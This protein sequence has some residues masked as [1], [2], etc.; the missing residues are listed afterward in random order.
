MKIEEKIREVITQAIEAGK[1]R[2]Y[3]KSITLLTEIVDSAPQYPAILLYLGRSYHALGNYHMAVQVLE[4]YNKL[5]PESPIGYF[6]LARTYYQLGHYKH[7]VKLLKFVIKKDPSFAFAHGLLGYIYLKLNKYFL[8]MESF[9]QSVELVPTDRRFFNGYLN[10]LLV[11][12]IKLFYKGE[13]EEAG[14]LF[15]YILNNRNSS[16]TAHLYLAFIFRDLGKPN[17]ALFHL[18]RVIEASGNDPILHLNRAIILLQKGDRSGGLF[19]L[20]NVAKIMNR[21]IK[22]SDDIEN[23]NRILAVTLFNDK[24]Y[25]KAIYFASKLLKL[26]YNQPDLHALIGES[27]RNLGEF[28]KA[29]NHFLRAIEINPTNVA[30]RYGLVMIYW[31]LS[32]YTEIIKQLNRIQHLSPDDSIASYYNTLAYAKLGND[33]TKIIALLQR[34]IKKTGPDIY[35]MNALGKAYLDASIPDLAVNWF[36]R[37]LRLDEKNEEALLYLLEAFKNLNNEPEL[38]ACYERYLKIK[39]ENVPIRKEFIRF[40]IDR[41][42][43]NKA[44][45]HIDIAL[46]Y[47]PQ[48]TKLMEVKAFCHRV[49][50]EFT[51]SY[52]TYFKLLSI[53]PDSIDYLLGTTYSLIKLDLLEKAT[54]LLQKAR[55][56]F[57]NNLS[58]LKFLAYCNY[59]SGNYEEALEIYRKVIGE[60]NRD[61]QAYMGLAN[62]YKKLGNNNF[63]ERFKLKA[64]EYKNSGGP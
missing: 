21:D 31:H 5:K 28:M 47:E 27:Y 18:D 38:V 15:Q 32:E 13:L 12:A 23:L 53:N 22:L 50:N 1:Q 24:K 7:A 57:K 3:K 6:F 51:Y 62:T 8:A 64:E 29:R 45:N 40:L 55:S 10:A 39:P 49:L 58:I 25:K 2:D 52:I 20:K 61:W 56:H 4:H 30:L 9:R 60:N 48:N 16:L 63:Y 17:A 36:K 43:F 46:S 37:S 11:Y 42:M 44:L 34:E 14:R 19:E 54:R 33:V 41:K 35:L 59:Q 26:N